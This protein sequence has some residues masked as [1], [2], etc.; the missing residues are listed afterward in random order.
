MSLKGG[1]GQAESP[2][3]SATTEIG[4]GSLGSPSDANARGRWNTPSAEG[5]GR[6]VSALAAQHAGKVDRLVA[7]LYLIQGGRAIAASFIGTGDFL[8]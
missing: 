3:R 2:T 7:W 6:V 1:T 4:N 8:H 5:R